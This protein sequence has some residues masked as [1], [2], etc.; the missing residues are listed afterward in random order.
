[1]PLPYN[2]TNVTDATN[3]V[4]AIIALDSATLLDGWVGRLFLI[5]LFI[6]IIAM[7][8]VKQAGILRASSAASFV[9]TIVAI[10]MASIGLASMTEVMIF[11]IAFIITTPL[12]LWLGGTGGKA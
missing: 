5:G 10:L 1:M 2:L 4:D 3:V 12:A 8:T 9:C 11:I 6:L 7:I